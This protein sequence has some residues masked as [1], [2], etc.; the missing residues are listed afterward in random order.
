MSDKKNTNEL[1]DEHLVSHNG[2]FCNRPKMSGSIMTPSL[3]KTK[4]I[5]ARQIKEM[6]NS[7]E[8][9]AWIDVVIEYSDEKEAM[10]LAKKFK[11]LADNPQVVLTIKFK[12]TNE[13]TN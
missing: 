10:R 7:G 13:V 8:K 9:K 12:N 11:S 5:P 6:L 2:M 3:T 1:F 4:K